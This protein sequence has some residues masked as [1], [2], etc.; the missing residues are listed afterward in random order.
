MKL[1][2][3]LI[4][5]VAFGVGQTLA[6]QSR[7]TVE[8]FFS[9]IGT[10]PSP[11]DLPVPEMDAKG[12]WQGGVISVTVTVDEKGAVSFVDGGDGPHPFCKSAKEPWVLALRASVVEAAKKSVF[13]PSTL[14]GKQVAVTGVLKYE[15]P[16]SAPVGKSGSSAGLQEMRLDRLTKIGSTDEPLQAR[17][18]GNTGVASSSG[19]LNGKAE[20]LQKPSYPAAAKAVRAGGMV[21][22]QVIIAEDGT[23]YSA[24]SISGHPLLRRASEVAAC[25]SRFTPTL[26]SGQPV[27]V[28]G[29]I[30]Y[31]FVP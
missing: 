5:L 19:V 17:I 9:V 22:V 23:I 13:I 10:P 21:A 6:Q 8:P 15:F 30:T 12:S 29:I 11:V 3:P 20:A 28:S 27:K 7:V 14:E 31:N 25:G 18:E 16:P 2:F 24:T 4:A 1:I 26:L